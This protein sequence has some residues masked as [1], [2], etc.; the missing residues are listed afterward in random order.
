MPSNDQILLEHLLQ[1]RKAEIAPEMSDN[2]FF[3][4]FV[5]EQILKQYDL[6]YDEI[7][8][9]IVGGPGDG[10]IDAVYVFVNGQL[11]VDDTDVSHL[12]RDITINLTVVQAKNTGGFPESALDRLITTTSE[13]LDFS[14]NLSRLRSHYNSDVVAAFSNFR[15]IHTS[16]AS[17]FPSLEISYFYAT[18]GLDIHPNV[19]RKVDTLRGIINRL[20]TDCHF[21]FTFL[22]SREL[23]RLARREPTRTHNLQIA[24]GPIT[25]GQV[26]YVCLV[27]LKDYY[28]FITD[29][30]GNLIKSMFD[31]NVRDYEGATEVNEAIRETLEAG[32]P[33]DFWWLN[34]GITVLGSRASLAG[35][36]L[37]VEDAKVV[38]G[39]QTSTEIFNY[40]RG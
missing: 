2:D 14:Q 3:E 24:E 34:N 25:S 26:G 37:T 29:E 6:S 23:L 17:K 1:Q 21:T 11:V 18:K 36:T 5:C 40:F 22:G 33:E 4:L 20:F 8:S 16:L 31:A 7:E 30:N 38:N 15:T 32:G 35:K 27:R 19:A 9:G 13:L 12:K 10:G 28:S 39:L